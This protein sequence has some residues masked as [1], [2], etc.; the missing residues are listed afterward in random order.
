MSPTS[1]GGIDLIQKIILPA[2]SER[3]PQTEHIFDNHYRPI[4]EI[5]YRG[6]P[7]GIDFS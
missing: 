5:G 3:L 4:F 6:S 1:G 7:L 2:R